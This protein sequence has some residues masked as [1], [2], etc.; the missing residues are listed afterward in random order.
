MPGSRRQRRPELGVGA[1]AGI[2]DSRHGVLPGETVQIKRKNTLSGGLIANAKTPFLSRN[3]VPQECRVLPE[4]A[5][6][7]EG[8]AGASYTNPPKGEVGNIH[9]GSQGEFCGVGTMVLEAGF[10]WTPVKRYSNSE[11]G[12]PDCLIMEINVPVRSS[13]WSGTGTVTVDSVN[14]NCMAI[15]L[16]RLLTSTKPCFA[17]IWQTSRP[18]RVRSLPNTDLQLSNINLVMKP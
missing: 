16:P 4:T 3:F 14:F 18:E 10:V 1:T 9:G 11:R 8:R 15:W 6:M 17:S 7:E 2:V 5:G 13:L 12:R